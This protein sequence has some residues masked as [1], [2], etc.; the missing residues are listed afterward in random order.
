MVFPLADGYSLFTCTCKSCCYVR[1]FSTVFMFRAFHSCSQSFLPSF[2]NF[3]FSLYRLIQILSRPLVLLHLWAPFYGILQNIFF[4]HCSK[5]SKNV[6]AI[7][8]TPK[9]F[10]IVSVFRTIYS[11][12]LS[13]IY[14]GII[15]NCSKNA[16]LFI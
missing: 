5:K 8:T 15:S 10:I 13:Y 3:Q 6:H 16:C 12:L 4:Y 9:F 7:Y 2:I 11:L 14:F 1:I